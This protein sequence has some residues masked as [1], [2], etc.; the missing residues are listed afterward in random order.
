MWAKTKKRSER[1]AS[2][3]DREPFSM[4]LQPDA[5]LH[6]FSHPSARCCWLQ[7]GI[8]ICTVCHSVLQITI[9]LFRGSRR[10][11][12]VF[13]E[14][15][16]C[17]YKTAAKPT[18]KNEN[19]PGKK[20]WDKNL[21]FRNIVSRL[22]KFNNASILMFL[23]VFQLINGKCLHAEN[24]RQVNLRFRPKGKRRKTETSTAKEKAKNK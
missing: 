14:S 6:V 3:L 4:N 10:F 15:F 13:W 12:R 18:R 17:D 7:I 23:L 5:S 9:I 20:G 11:C 19:V 16:D 2:K 24:C 1:G 21:L 22:G 8:E